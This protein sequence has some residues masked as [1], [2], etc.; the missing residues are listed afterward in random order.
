LYF[1]AEPGKDLTLWNC[2]IDQ[3][4]TKVCLVMYA[5]VNYGSV[6]KTIWD[7]IDSDGK[8]FL[9]YIPECYIAKVNQSEMK[10]TFVNGSILQCIGADTHKTSFRGSNPYGIILSEFAYY[11]DPTVLDTVMP[12]V[13]ANSGWVALASTPQGKNTFHAL[14]KMAQELP[15]WWV[16]YKKTSEIHHIDPEELEA[17]RKRMSPELF[18]Q[19]YECSFDRGIDGSIFGKALNTLRLNGHITTVT[20]EPGLLVHTAWDIG[21]SQGNAGGKTI[22]IFFQVVG[23]GTVIRIIDVYSSHTIGLDAYAGILQEKPY[24]YGIHLGP[25]DLM[26]REWGG[27]AVTRYEK[28]KNLDINFTVLKQTL[29]SDQ[30]ETALTHFPKIWIDEVKCKSLID[31]LENYYREWDEQRQVY[32]P[33]PVH[34][35]AS[36]YASAFM[37]IF[38]GLH[39]CM[40]SKPAQEYDKIRNEALYGEGY[41]ALPR[42]FRKGLKEQGF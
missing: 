35:W 22:I 36:D 29:L 8:R 25:H 32:R 10:I 28:A 13:A 42:I 37:G 33:K 40:T 14:Y 39:H 6:R 15:N 38:I 27:G 34:N 1:R 5:G 19:E 24:R 2:A 21:L 12:I 30:I 7:A 9:E 3:C 11:D 4:L 23:D 18:A 16:Y 41:S 17:E 26:V 31:A 20:W